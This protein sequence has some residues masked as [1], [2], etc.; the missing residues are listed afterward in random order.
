MS[1]NSLP[2]DIALAHV[3]LTVANLERALTFYQHA[4]GFKVHR[5]E[6]NTAHLGA[7]G[8]DLVVLTEAPKARPYPGRTGL[9]HYAILVPSR[10]ALA[11]SLQRIAATRTPV[12]GFAD[13]Y[14]SEAIYL[15]DPDRNGIE[16]Y[17]DRPRRDWY[18]ENGEFNMGTDPLDIDSVLK[19][20]EGHAG[21]WN[22]LDPATALGHVHLHVRSIPEAMQFYC[23]VLGFDLMM[24]L[25][26]ALFVSAG[27]YHH[28]IGLNIWGTLNASPPPPDA[29]GL[30]HFIV[31][32]PGKTDSDRLLDRLHH[33]G[34]PIEDHPE[35]WLVRDPSHNSLVWSTS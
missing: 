3:H 15:P 25:G 12:Q 26:S 1:D 9:Y 7:G 29:V 33:D 10:L 20:L 32:L 8:P 18:G 35:G 4:L 6:G 5:H 23:G 14:V 16:I 13:H 34:V 30:R 19:E 11:Q 24:N 21:G 31:K 17:R 22:G 2:P 27:G 28:H